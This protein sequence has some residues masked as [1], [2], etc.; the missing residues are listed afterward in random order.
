MI[1]EFQ[2]NKDI[3]HTSLW[4]I[5]PKLTYHDQVEIYRAIIAVI[6]LPFTIILGMIKGCSVA[7]YALSCAD[8]MYHD[9][10]D[11][12]I[13]SPMSFYDTIS[14]GSIINRF[15]KDLDEGKLKLN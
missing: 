9:M 13:K 12:L 4:N 2:E 3:S 5:G 7:K 11:R 15:V 6:F 14:V 8:S 10:L 1:N